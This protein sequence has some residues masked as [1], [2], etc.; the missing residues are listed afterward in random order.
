MSSDDDHA[1]RGRRIA[2]FVAG[3]GLAWIGLT[4]LGAALALDQR[5]RALIDLAILAGFGW[6]IWMIYGLWRDRQAD[7]D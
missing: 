4:A 7:K 6:A 3:L 1:R 2:L 5:F